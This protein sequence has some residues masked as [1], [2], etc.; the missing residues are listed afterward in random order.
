[1]NLTENLIN[2]VNFKI[3]NDNILAYEFE[4]TED[5]WID[6]AETECSLF[7]WQ[8]DKASKQ[9]YVFVAWHDDYDISED[10]SYLFDTKSLLEYFLKQ[11]TQKQIPDNTIDYEAY[12]Q[13]R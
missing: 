8:F 10:V 7:R 5:I 11:E 1:M 4:T 13:E 12:Y 2:T 3:E 6:E 9:T